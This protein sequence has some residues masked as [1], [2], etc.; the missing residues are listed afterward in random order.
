MG[1][2]GILA[3]ACTVL[4]I[5]ASLSPWPF[6]LLPDLSAFPFLSW[7]ISVTSD[8]TEHHY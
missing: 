4:L 6:Q 1:E 8:L 3:K 7:T 5:C 2:E